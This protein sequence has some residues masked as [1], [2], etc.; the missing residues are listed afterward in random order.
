MSQEIDTD[1][2]ERLAKNPFYNLNQKQIEQ[3]QRYRAKKYEE[4]KVL[5]HKTNFKKHDP[6]I[7]E[8]SN[9]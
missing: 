2:Y 4:S 9:D 3:M 8:E 5:R 1:Q 7:K 6:K